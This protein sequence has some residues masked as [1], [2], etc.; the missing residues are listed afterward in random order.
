MSKKNEKDSSCI[1]SNMGSGCCKVETVVSID[2]KGQILLPKE[3]REKANIQAGDKLFVV[4]W[5]DKPGP[6]CMTLIKANYLED[7]VKNF[8]GPMMKEFT[9]E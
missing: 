5:G 2:S 8:L 9:Q 7:M 3:L 1:P 4:T 6:C